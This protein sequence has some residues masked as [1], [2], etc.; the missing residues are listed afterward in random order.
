VADVQAIRGEVYAL[1]ASDTSGVLYRL[2]GATGEIK[3]HVAVGAN[4][5]ELTGL[6]DGRIAVVNAGDNTLWLVTPS[7]S[8]MTAEKVLTFASQTATLQDVRAYGN[9]LFTV[10]SG[11][12]T[13]QKIDLGFKGGPKVVAEATFGQGAGPYNIL[14]LD[15]DQAIVANRGTNTIAAAQWVVAK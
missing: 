13:A 1:C 7:A 3:S 10:A 2:D 12:N 6:D 14:P 5:S 8:G 4:P 15:E 9:F 11:S